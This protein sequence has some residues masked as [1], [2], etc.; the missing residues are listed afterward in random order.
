VL[1]RSR[2]HGARRSAS[3]SSAR[4]P[5]ASSAGPLRGG[6]ALG[7]RP[8]AVCPR[9]RGRALP[10][11]RSRPRRVAALARLRAP[12][13]AG[14]CA[15]PPARFRLVPPPPTLWLDGEGPGCEKGES[16]W[17]AL[18]VSSICFY[19]FSGHPTN[20]VKTRGKR[21]LRFQKAGVKSHS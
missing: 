2:A 19:F 6:A 13:C 18:N 8:A 17:I 12:V 1:G 21:W 15:R 10:P 5:A 11:A 20:R 3:C 9:R 7:R 16:F 4:G 14:G